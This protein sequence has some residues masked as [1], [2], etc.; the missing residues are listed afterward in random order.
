MPAP[1]IHVTKRPRIPI[2][3]HVSIS[4]LPASL[5]PGDNTPRIIN[6]RGT[7]SYPA[8][9]PQPQYQ[10]HQKGNG[11]RPEVVVGC[12]AVSWRMRTGNHV[13]YRDA[14]DDSG[15]VGHAGSSDVRDQIDQHPRSAAQPENTPH[16][17][18]PGKPRPEQ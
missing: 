2:L 9:R 7:Q 11:Y 15:L 18:R 5:K 1:G 8:Q 14:G 10:G 6:D 12:T 13:A 4:D 3:S 16:G 17:S